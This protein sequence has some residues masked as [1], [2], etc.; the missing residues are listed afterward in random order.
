MKFY[1]KTIGFTV[2]GLACVIWIITPFIGFFNLSSKQLVIYVP[3]LI[4]C[5]EIFFLIAIAFLGKEYWVKVKA[6]MGVKWNEVKNK[7]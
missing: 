7:L 2:L 6:Y 4:I 1:K 5:G 3:I